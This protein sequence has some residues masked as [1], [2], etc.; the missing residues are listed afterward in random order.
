MY[1]EVHSDPKVQLLPPILFRAWVNL[2]CLANMNEDILPPIT[3]ISYRLHITEAKVAEFVNTLIEKNL[4]EKRS[5]GQIEPHNW[6]NRQ[7]KSDGSTE[8]VKRFRNAKRNVS[9]TV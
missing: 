7:F 1:N 4:F 8:R 6:D 9:V 5:N 3:E 2:M